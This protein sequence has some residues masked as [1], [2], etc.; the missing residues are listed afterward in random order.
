M[1]VVVFI[2]APVL[3]GIFVAATV[4]TEPL[5]VIALWLGTAGIFGGAAG[6]WSYL[7]YGEDAQIGAATQRG[8]AIGFVVGFFVALMAAMYLL[9]S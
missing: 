4:F 1:P 3:S 2:V 8:A 6:A 7:T 9:L 5:E